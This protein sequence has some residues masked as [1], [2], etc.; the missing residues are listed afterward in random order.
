MSSSSSDTENNS[1]QS[2]DSDWNYIP[3]P[4]QIEKP[5]EIDKNTGEAQWSSADNE[6]DIGPYV[7]EPVADE[8]WL[9][10][11][12]EKRNHTTNVLRNYNEGLMVQKNWLNGKYFT[13]TLLRDL[14]LCFVTCICVYINTVFKLQTTIFQV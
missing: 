2:D 4:Y 7:N 3:G 8:D 13:L 10:N 9:A 14:T 1:Y 5:S 12:R 11:Y 6:Q